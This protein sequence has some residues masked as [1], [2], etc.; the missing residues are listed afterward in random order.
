MIKIEKVIT[1]LKQRKKNWEKKIYVIKLLASKWEKKLK[2]IE[3]SISR[4]LTINKI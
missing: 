3:S 4:L 2:K 1:I